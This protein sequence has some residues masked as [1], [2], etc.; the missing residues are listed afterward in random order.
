MAKRLI[1]KLN[2]LLCD[3][4]RNGKALVGSLASEDCATWQAIEGVGPSEAFPVGSVYLSITGVNPATELGY[5]TWVAFG[6]GRMP[7]GYAAGDP[8]FGT[9]EATGGAKTKAISAHAGTAVAAHPSHTHDF[10]DVINHV[11]TVVVSDPGHAHAQQRH[12]ATTGALT[13]ITT[14]PD[15]SSATPAAMGPNTA[16]ATT[17]ITASTQAPAGGKATGTT[18]APS[19][20]LTHAVTQPNDH[21]AVN[22]VPPFIVVHMWK[23]TA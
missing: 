2:A 23:R 7:V 9:V 18:G 14:A 13:G 16:S 4:S 10:A 5:G 12:S 17:G 1:Q 11:H 19:A 6:A 8:D 3:E 21:S 20:S 22:V 15:T